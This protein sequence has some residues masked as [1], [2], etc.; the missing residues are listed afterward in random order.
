M[1]NA[2]SHQGGSP[3][4]EAAGSAPPPP[5]ASYKDKEPTKPASPPPPTTPLLMP[6]GGHLSPQNP[7]ALGLPQAH[8]YS[9]T[10]VT[11]LILD[12]RL[13][14]F[15]RG[16]DDYEEDWSE[17]QVA[18]ELEETRE[19]DFAEQVE[20]SSTAQLREERE[21][22]AR[23]RRLSHEA[24]RAERQRREE[25][26]YL[27]AI[28][29]PIC[30]LYYPPNINT[31]RCCQQPLCTECFVQMKRAEATT[32]HLE[33]EPASCP[34][35]VETDFGVI[36]ERPTAALPTPSGI[37][38][39]GGTA[40]PAP[41][42]ALATSPD[43]GASEFSTALSDRPLSPG[44]S[45]L[46]ALRE[47]GKRRKSVSCKA[48]E[49]VTIDAI[50]PDWEAKLNAV[51]AQAARRAARRIVMRQVG[52]RLIPIGYT[53]SRA[54]GQAD[55]SMSIPPEESGSRRSRRTREREREMEEMM[56]MEAM[57]LSLLDQEE[58][59]RKHA[60]DI[61]PGQT[62][63]GPSAGPSTD[64]GSSNGRGPSGT[65][66]P[67]PSTS[68]RRSSRAADTLSSWRQNEGGRAAKLLSKITV[69][70][71][72]ANSKSSVHF[73][74][75]PPTF[76][77]ASPS[78]NRARSSSTPSPAPGLHSE[79]TPSPLSNAVTRRSLDVP[80]TG[81]GAALAL[82]AAL[83]P[84]EP[85][86]AEVATPMTE[87]DHD[88][89]TREL[90]A[91]TDDGPAS[92]LTDS[93]GQMDAE[94]VPTPPAI[95]VVVEPPIDS[96]VTELAAPTPIEAPVGQ[97]LLSFGNLGPDSEA[98]PRDSPLSDTTP[99]ASPSGQAAALPDPPA[100]GKALAA[101]IDVPK[102]SGPD[103]DKG[104]ETPAK[105]ELTKV[106]PKSPTLSPFKPAPCRTDTSTSL[107]SVDAASFIS[108]SSLGD[109][110]VIRR[111]SGPLA[112]R[113]DD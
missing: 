12:Q 93:P 90:A 55:F 99:A 10:I 27:G 53:S 65:S 82:Q 8:D 3:P 56:I 98:T 108:R 80:A 113:A 67:T 7:H 38:S 103:T 77:S 44:S 39:P 75:S 86:I 92:L 58:Y 43:G 40:S 84:A 34:F 16:L 78:G 81:R 71:S 26:A 50:R 31:S 91:A 104:P 21:T 41:L 49:V 70:R 66:S 100:T 68:S 54:T 19:K 95:P 61:Q 102:T 106:T 28:E 29:C 59:Q 13:A 94:V 35:C 36:Y 112:A 14:P 37:L 1:G 85:A 110:E 63:A 9:K 22:I 47:E 111:P 97:D 64:N 101:P 30:F 4:F 52:D 51:K 20:N 6:Y 72:R 42:S 17:A 60:H 45:D 109:D 79:H 32:T 11:A 15:Y 69:N 74:P 76:G 73:A 107:V 62:A 23:G 87:T 57:R 88:P 46:A 24:E 89:L 2:P 18:H 48:K 25:K 96:P 33:S 5:P 105:T 83:G